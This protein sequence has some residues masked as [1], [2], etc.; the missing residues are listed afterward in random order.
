MT[1][2]VLRSGD[3]DLEF[4]AGTV[5]SAAV[6]DA[7]SATNWTGSLLATASGGESQ[8]N[9]TTTNNQIESAVA[10]DS[11]GNYVVVWTAENNQDGNG[12]GVYMQ[13]FNASGVA[14]G[15]ETE[16]GEGQRVR[17]GTLHSGRLVE[18]DSFPEQGDSFRTPM[19]LEQ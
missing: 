12:R 4:S 19:A 17:Q 18:R 15:A 13:R 9:A 8:V 7:I 1:R 16:P 11:S 6:L 14:Q 5:E 3:W 10:M 2:N